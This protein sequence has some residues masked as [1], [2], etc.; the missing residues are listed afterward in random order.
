MQLDILIE[1]LEKIKKEKGNVD[2]KFESDPW[3]TSE[4]CGLYYDEDLQTIKLH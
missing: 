3:S 2:V 1:S 4:I